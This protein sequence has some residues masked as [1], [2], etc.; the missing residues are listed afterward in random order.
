[1]EGKRRDEEDM[2]DSLVVESN[3]PLLLPELRELSHL[4]RKMKLTLAQKQSDYTGPYCQ[5]VG[6]QWNWH[7]FQLEFALRGL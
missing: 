6:G 3:S 7:I 5:T 1:M 4:L 2:Q